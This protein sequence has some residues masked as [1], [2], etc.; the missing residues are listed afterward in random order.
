VTDRAWDDVKPLVEAKCGGCHNG[1]VHP[2]RFDTG[3]KFKASKA[4][5]RIS[6]GTMPPSGGLSDADKQRLL[7]YLGA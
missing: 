1:T 2:L 6:N 3:A 5:L 4:K 7:T